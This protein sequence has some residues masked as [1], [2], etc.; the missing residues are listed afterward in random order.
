[1]DSQPRSPSLNLK[2]ATGSDVLLWP[3]YPEHEQVNKY[4][5][6]IEEDKNIM[7]SMLRSV[8]QIA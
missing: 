2:H 6:M 4:G 3:Q 5:L 7:F 1:M 8:N